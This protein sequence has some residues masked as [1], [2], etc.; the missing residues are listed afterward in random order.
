MVAMDLKNLQQCIR[1]GALQMTAEVAGSRPRRPRHNSE[2][3][4][5]LN[6][7]SSIAAAS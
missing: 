2:K 6:D 4:R 3:M 7:V 1:P 5:E